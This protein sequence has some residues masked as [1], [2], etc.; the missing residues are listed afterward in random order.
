M[1]YTVIKHIGHLNHSGIHDLGFFL[2]NDIEATWQ[3][4]S[5]SLFLFYTLIKHG[6]L[7]K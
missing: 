3:K 6:F 4:Q 7:T 1:Y 5:F 2:L